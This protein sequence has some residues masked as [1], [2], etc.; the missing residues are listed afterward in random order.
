MKKNVINSLI[1][2]MAAASLIS[3]SG[4]ISGQCVNPKYKIVHFP[5][6]SFSVIR[7]PSSLIRLNGPPIA[8]FPAD[9]PSLTALELVFISRGNNKNPS[10]YTH[11]R[12]E[13][14]SNKLLVDTGFHNKST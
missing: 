13:K 5:I 11:I 4:Q 2:S 6:K 10:Q 14:K 12:T 9:G 8:A 3:S 1:L 7:F